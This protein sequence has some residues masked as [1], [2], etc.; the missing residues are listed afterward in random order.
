[1]S[2]RTN[3]EWAE[4]NSV[5]LDEMVKQQLPPIERQMMNLLAWA[6]AHLGDD[7]LGV[8]E[9]PDEEDLTAIIGT[10]DGGRVDDL[11]SR[12]GSDGLIAF[13]PDHCLSITA[14][15]WSKL[16]P[17]PKEVAADENAPTQSAPKVDRVEKA[18]C[19][20]CHGLKNS[21]V[22]AEYVVDG[23]DGA[24]SWRDTCEVLQCCGCD[25]LSFRHRFWF[26]EWDY[27]DRDE[28]GRE[29]MRPGVQEKSFPPPTVRAKP[30]W[31]DGIADDVLRDVL[32]E[33]YAALNFGTRVLASI[34]ARTLLDRAGYLLLQDD[35]KGGFEAKLAGLV[36]GGFITSQE[37]ETLDAMADAG[38]A[39]AHRGYNPTS[40]RL[41]QIVD[42]IENFLH[43]AFVLSGAAEEIRKS[44][45]P[46]KGRT[47]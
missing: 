38:N 39:S 28:Y 1:M 19:N 5:N 18:H 41:G 32:E 15:G 8:V 17:A 40:E 31:A 20:K 47:S 24:T 45:P 44:T 14:K 9:L 25:G 11:I 10:I 30:K 6:A 4:I 26:S 23:S 2:E 43:R 12:A 37:K 21:W 16:M 36:A 7:Q 42:I 34:G 13:I 35:P 46:R 3:A 29:V 22:R 33:L 27:I